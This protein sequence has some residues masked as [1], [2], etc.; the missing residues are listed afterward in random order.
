VSLV[1]VEPELEEAI[2]GN[3][4][5]ALEVEEQP[6]AA[7]ELS[8]E[9]AE[10]DV[11]ASPAVTS[12]RDADEVDRYLWSVYQRSGTK[13]DSHGDFTW[14]DAVA[15]E[16]LGLSV[17]DYVIGGMDPDFREQLYHL[18]RAMDAA[19][20][21]WTILSA[22]RDDYRQNLASG[23]KA[24]TGNSFHGGTLA[25]G[26]YGHGCAVDLASTDGLSNEELWR[27]LDQ[28]GDRFGIF[29][30]LRGVDPA[31][32]QARGPWHALA[33]ALRVERVGN[34]LGDVAFPASADR[35]SSA[36]LTEEQYACVRPRVIEEASLTMRLAGHMKPLGVHL[37]AAEPDQ[38]HSK[39]KA[40]P[41]S[42]RLIAS[43]TDKSQ[44]KTKV[45]RLSVRLIAS[46][47]DKGRGNAKAR[48]ADR[49]ALRRATPRR[50]PPPNVSRHAAAER[51]LDL[52]R[53]TKCA[54]NRLRR[55]S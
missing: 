25:T 8:E 7:P 30:P 45:K 50:P 35:S 21:D 20:I 40:K 9:S 43:E 54:C 10:P 38:S 12:S 31:H 39:A 4:A 53:P 23:F 17:Q 3:A 29:R 55:S 48:T 28:H 15:A 11:A 36:G 19:G 1:R 37:V 46:P 44:G 41:L 24:H 2:P 26:G 27:W 47:E 32:L 18:G 14:K 42:V 16:R 22:F 33:A 5:P 49:V 52:A 51:G 13:L 34:E 6:A